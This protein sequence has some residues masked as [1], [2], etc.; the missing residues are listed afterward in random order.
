MKKQIAVLSNAL[1]MAS[2]A[3]MVGAMA[4]GRSSIIAPL[5]SSA[6]T[7]VFE[8][9]WLDSE[10]SNWNQVGA[11]LPSAPPQE[12]DNFPYCTESFTWRQAA[13]PEDEAVEAAGWKIFGAAQIFGATTVVTAMANVDGMCRPMDYQAF[14]FQDGQFIGTLSPNAMAARAEASLVNYELSGEGEIMATFNRYTNDDALCCPSGESL[15]FY[16]I[17]SQDGAS[18]LVPELPAS[19]SPNS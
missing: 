3:M 5:A 13:F 9:S 19:T 16:R 10:T 15:V 1:V 12:G 14:V 8:P 4:P 2:L 18:I 17:E 6:A 7:P 11:A